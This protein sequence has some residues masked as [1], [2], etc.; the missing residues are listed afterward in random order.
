MILL[1]EVQENADSYIH[2]LISD[3]PA[4]QAMI[5]IFRTQHL[6]SS[7]PSP[8]PHLGRIPS[9][10]TWTAPQPGQHLVA[11]QAVPASP[12]P[13]LCQLP[14]ALVAHVSTST[15]EPGLGTW[16]GVVRRGAVLFL[17]RVRGGVRSAVKATPQNCLFGKAQDRVSRKS[18]EEAADGQNPVERINDA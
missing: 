10:S 8:K 7:Q 18:A 1:I 2:K 15:E 14:K 4:S 16:P 13:L 5:T 11:R 6:A 9:R 3:Q 12:T 17:G